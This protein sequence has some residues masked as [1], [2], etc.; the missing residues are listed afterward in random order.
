MNH[1][2]RMDIVGI[3]LL[4]AFAGADRGGLRQ[5]RRLQGTETDP[6]QRF[7]IKLINMGRIKRT[8]TKNV[9]LILGYPQPAC[10]HVAL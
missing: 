5:N 4:L 3:M 10:S 2:M 1:S 8:Q 7:N 6:S 9:A